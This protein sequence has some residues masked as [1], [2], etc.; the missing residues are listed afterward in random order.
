MT[1]RKHARCITTNVSDQQGE[2]TAVTWLIRLPRELRDIIYEYTLTEEGGLVADVLINTY[3]LARF[4]AARAVN[5]NRESN[6]LRLVCRQ[7]HAETSGL[8]LQYNDITF[9]DSKRDG[10]RVS[11]YEHFTRFVENSA[12]TQ[13]AS[14]SRIVLLG[15]WTILSDYPGYDT[16]ALYRKCTL[17]S[18][19]QKFCNNFPDT[20]VIVR[21]DKRINTWFL[22]QAHIYDIACMNAI[23]QIQRGKDLFLSPSKLAR[24]LASRVTQEF[25]TMFGFLVQRTYASPTRSLSMKTWLERDFPCTT[26]RR[27][28]N[29]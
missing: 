4:R 17:S 19:V 25:R 27:M 1:V 14:I 24:S 21:L 16:T 26:M 5:N 15:G 12:T 23:Y 6:Q 20:T 13:L 18:S 10:E 7:L 22:L 29:A 28:L 9:G 8:G 11:A 3:G 2:L